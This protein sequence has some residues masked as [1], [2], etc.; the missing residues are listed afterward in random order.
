MTDAAA[1]VAVEGTADTA[2][3]AP[4]GADVIMLIIEDTTLGRGFE[5]DG[6]E[7]GSELDGGV[8]VGLCNDKYQF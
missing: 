2:L 6:N 5:N 8:S 7:S 4:A 1:A 3:T